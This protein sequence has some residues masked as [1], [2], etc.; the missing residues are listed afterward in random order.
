MILAIQ[1]L[2]SNRCKENVVVRSLQL[3]RAGAVDGDKSHDFCMS[4][5]RFE[6]LTFVEP[7]I[8]NKTGKGSA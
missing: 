1:Q 5:D 3:S 7:V 6:V 8:T 4:D 2:Y